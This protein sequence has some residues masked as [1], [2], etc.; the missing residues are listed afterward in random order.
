MRP[1]SHAQ[2]EFNKRLLALEKARASLERKRR[3]LDKDL[4]TCREILMPELEQCMRIKAEM[5]SKLHNASKAL[6]LSKR[7]RYALEDLIMIK[8]ENLVLNAVG[9]TEEQTNALEAIAME[10]AP[11][12][13]QDDDSDRKFMRLEFEELR[14]LLEQA[15][16]EAG[17][18]LDLSGIDPDMDPEELQSE[19][20]RRLAAC[21]EEFHRAVCGEGPQPQRKRKQ[22]KAALERER[23]QAEAEEAKKR[24]IK[25]LF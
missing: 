5:L 11:A 24:D 16:R 17:V 4:V 21:G 10:I 9:L 19:L 20:H 12:T 18:K 6:N 1:L 13:E 23:L 22:G 7:R 25:T 2:I 8:I 3:L 15:A 14:A